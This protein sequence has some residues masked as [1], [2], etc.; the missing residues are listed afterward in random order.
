MASPRRARARTISRRTRCTGGL[1]RRGTARRAGSNVP[2]GRS[3][4][5]GA[6][7]RYAV[8][9]LPIAW[10]T[11]TAECSSRT[12]HCASPAHSRRPCPPPPTL[13]TQHVAETVGNRGRAAPVEPGLPKIDVRMKCAAG[14]ALPAP[15]CSLAIADD[16]RNPDFMTSLVRGHRRS[17][18]VMARGRTRWRAG[19][20]STRGCHNSG[21]GEERSGHPRY[22]E[23]RGRTR[24]R[25]SRRLERVRTIPWAVSLPCTGRSPCRSRVSGCARSA[26]VGEQPLQLRLPARVPGRVLGFRRRPRN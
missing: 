21:A 1:L 10:P 16:G 5:D 15:W 13:Q 6:R 23:D 3:D 12:R 22:S 8:K 17:K 14:R 7:L 18:D 4:H 25:L 26:V 20:S 19:N 2:A 9:M 11:P 24:P